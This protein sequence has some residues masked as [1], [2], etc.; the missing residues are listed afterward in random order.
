MFLHVVAKFLSPYRLFH[1]IVSW[2]SFALQFRI[3]SFLDFCA[4][5]GKKTRI[6]M[7]SS[8]VV[9]RR[10]FA[11]GLRLWQLCISFFYFFFYHSFSFSASLVCVCVCFMCEFSGKPVRR[12]Y[13]IA[14]TLALQSK[15]IEPVWS[16]VSCRKV[17]TSAWLSACITLALVPGLGCIRTNGSSADSS[18]PSAPRKSFTL[19]A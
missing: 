4:G 7:E 10:S 3:T 9:V 11:F 12:S 18:P 8:I 5:E 15:S 16:T 2:S 13:R 14:I 19:T 17:S 1:P 6:G